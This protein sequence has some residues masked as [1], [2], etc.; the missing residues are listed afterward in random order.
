M[1]RYKEHKIDTH[2]S[3]GSKTDRP[4]EGQVD[5]QLSTRFQINQPSFVKN[6]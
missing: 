3:V 6:C 5:L 4:R 2:V 1:D